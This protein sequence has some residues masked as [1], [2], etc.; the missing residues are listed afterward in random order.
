M[1]WVR[2]HLSEEGI[3]EIKRIYKPSHW[4]IEFE[5]FGMHAYT[6]DQLSDL[7]RKACLYPGS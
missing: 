1:T 5:A 2:K 4:L 7:F 6:A 3:Q